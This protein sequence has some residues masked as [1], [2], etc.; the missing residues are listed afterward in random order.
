MVEDYKTATK[1]KKNNLNMT[2]WIPEYDSKYLTHSSVLFTTKHCCGHKQIL[3]HIV[4]N[5]MTDRDITY[6]ETT[7]IPTYSRLRLPTLHVKPIIII[8][9]NA[10][11]L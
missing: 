3:V 9:I 11:T 8:I 10:T 5:R 4:M 2:A 6:M 1:C 7:Q